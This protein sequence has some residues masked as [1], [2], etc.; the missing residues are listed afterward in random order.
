MHIGI[1]CTENPHSNKS[2][3]FFVRVAVWW[4]PPGAQLD[5]PCITFRENIIMIIFSI[6]KIA[7]SLISQTGTTCLWSVV[8]REI[9]LINLKTQ[10]ELTK[11]KFKCFEKLIFKNL[12]G[13]VFSI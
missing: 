2:Y 11:S 5:M 6:K 8:Y 12:L 3:A 7:R 4:S 10:F 1:E 9:G 13:I